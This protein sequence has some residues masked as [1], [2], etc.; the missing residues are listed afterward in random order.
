MSKNNVFSFNQKRDFSEI[1]PLELMD[2]AKTELNAQPN[3]VT[4]QRAIVVLVH[5]FGK[6]SDK[7]FTV[8]IQLMNTKELDPLT[9]VGVLDF[10]KD[11]VKGGF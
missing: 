1:E 3:N 4:R 11:K 10:C 9:M 8:R 6:P 2:A 5:D 7:N